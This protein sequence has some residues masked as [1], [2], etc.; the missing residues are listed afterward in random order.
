MTPPPEEVTAQPAG[1]ASFEA[2]FHAEYH[3]LV[4]LAAAIS[5]RRGRAEDIV[6]EAM[7]R[8]D[9]EWEVVSTYERPGAWLRRVTINLALSQRR[10]IGRE[11]RALL[12][13]DRVDGALDPDPPAE[14]AHVWAAV[15]ELPGKQRA[16]VAM[17]YLEDAS[18]DQIAE[19]LD[20]APATARV[21]LHRGRQAL[22][23]RLTEEER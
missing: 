19:A 10:R 22:R 3:G 12:R 1:A 17:H 20:I 5:G 18:V 7:A 6:Q 14:H 4:A 9:R 16:A 2:V 8:L 15:A 13:L 23:E 11:A 21:H